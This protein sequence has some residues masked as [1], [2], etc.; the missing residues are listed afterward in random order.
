MTIE[1]RHDNDLCRVAETQVQRRRTIDAAVAPM[2]A[3][4]GRMTDRL[5]GIE[6][7]HEAAQRARH[8]RELAADLDRR[9]RRADFFDA[10]AR[11]FRP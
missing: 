3:A 7:K 5:D 4:L 1:Q 6:A 10:R 9:T 11:G 2:L 8:F